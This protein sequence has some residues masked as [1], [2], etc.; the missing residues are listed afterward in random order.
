LPSSVLRPARRFDQ[1]DLSSQGAGSG[2]HAE[3]K[4]EGRPRLAPWTGIGM[5]FGGGCYS[6]DDRFGSGRTVTS[7]EEKDRAGAAPGASIREMKKPLR[8]DLGLSGPFS[9]FLRTGK[10]KAEQL[11]SLR[12]LLRLLEVVGLMLRPFCVQKPPPHTKAKGTIFSTSSSS[13][14]LNA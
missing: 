8:I 6:P 10:K 3:A 7:Q 11:T 12:F 13:I 1:R 4:S 5:S 14:L 2:S 9:R